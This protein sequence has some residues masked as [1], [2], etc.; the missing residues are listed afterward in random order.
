MRDID[1]IYIFGIIAELVFVIA[2]FYQL[3]FGKPDLA[4]MR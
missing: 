2:L 1:V 3:M 4:D